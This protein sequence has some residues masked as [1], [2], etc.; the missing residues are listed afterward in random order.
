MEIGLVVSS[1]SICTLKEATTQFGTTQ[2]LLA[3]VSEERPRTATVG[4][5]TGHECTTLAVA[6]ES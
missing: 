6:Q 3:A 2:R 1:V 5:V 4:D